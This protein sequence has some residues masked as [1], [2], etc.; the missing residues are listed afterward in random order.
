MRQDQEKL[1]MK[2]VTEYI[3]RMPEDVADDRMNRIEKEGKKHIHFA[4][5]GFKEPGKPHYYRL[6]GPSFF[7]EYDNTQNNANHIHTVWRD[8]QDDWGE[9][10]LKQHYKRSHQ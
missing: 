5:A 1:L 6:H 8:I 4:W 3:L 7:V 9:D 10:L 2:L